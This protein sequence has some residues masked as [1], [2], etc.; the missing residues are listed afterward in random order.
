MK[1]LKLHERVDDLKS[2][3]IPD[4]EGP[5]GS[6]IYSIKHWEIFSSLPTLQVV[7]A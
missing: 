3:A 5:N 1:N 4:L 2:L 6:F 7:L